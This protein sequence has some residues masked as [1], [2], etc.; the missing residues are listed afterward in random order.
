M[1]PLLRVLTKFIGR[2]PRVTNIAFDKNMVQAENREDMTIE[3]RAMHEKRATVCFQM[4]AERV[5][6][7]G[8]CMEK[9]KQLYNYVIAG[10]M[11]RK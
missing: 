4:D 5:K 3:M 11:M 6:E 10:E 2:N 9:R 1:A 7:M 8:Q